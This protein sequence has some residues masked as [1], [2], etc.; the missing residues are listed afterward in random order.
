MSAPD[1]G[2]T[3]SAASRRGRQRL[4]AVG[5][6][7]GAAVLWLSSRLTWIDVDIFDDK[8]G[9]QAVQMTG[10]RWSTELTALALVIAA[11]A[12]AVV[13]LS[14]P[15]RRVVGAV[16]AVA[17]AYASWPAVAML[18]GGPDHAS[19]RA[20]LTSG[21]EAAASSSS[22][23]DVAHMSD[24][25]EITATHVSAVG[26]VCTV[27]G[28]VVAVIAAVL[29]VMHPGEDSAGA[30]KYERAQTRREKLEADL[31]LAPDSGRV[32]WDALDADLD[33]TQRPQHP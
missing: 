28:A 14:R 22:S 11:A 20:I 7:V 31:D 5:L 25:A 15:W 12:I 23:A 32:M 27:L 26:P 30:N 18:S 19:V 24:W 1:G 8:S 16:A 33:P 29:V 6:A 2:V 9:A 10:A 21:R 3:G 17:A 13:V 4:A